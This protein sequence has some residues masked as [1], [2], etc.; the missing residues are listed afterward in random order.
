M[1]MAPVT[2]VALTMTSVLLHGYGHGGGLVL[3]LASAIG[4]VHGHCQGLGH[5]F[6]TAMATVILH[7]HYTKAW[8]C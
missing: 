1:G 8:S 6:P 4:A 2:V 7:G 3:G 5:S